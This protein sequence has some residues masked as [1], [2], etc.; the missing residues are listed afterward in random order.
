MKTRIII[1]LAGIALLGG[2]V[3]APSQLSDLG[4]ETASQTVVGSAT[5]VGFFGL[6]RGKEVVYE[7]AL[8][9]A[10]INAP[11]GTSKLSDVKLWETN[12]ISANIGITLLAVA[13][14]L[15]IGFDEVDAAL[16]I[17][18]ALAFLASGLEVTK[19]TVVGVPVE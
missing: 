11:S 10:L 2:C 1:C 17:V 16:A 8:K 18:E 5:Y 15:V 6:G 7:Q 19:F 9:K 3:T 13:V 14:P 12:Y 4:D